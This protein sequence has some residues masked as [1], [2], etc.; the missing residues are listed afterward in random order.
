MLYGLLV[1][2]VHTMSEVKMTGNCL[3]GS[4]PILTFDKNFDSNPQ[5]AL[6]KEIMTQVFC[7]PTHD[8][9]LLHCRCLEVPRLTQ[10]PNLLLIT[11]FHFLLLTIVFGF[12]IIRSNSL[13]RNI[14]RNLFVFHLTLMFNF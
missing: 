10:K 6:I 12:A 13:C 1:F 3:K 8:F 7:S 2:A 14:Y 4:R 9:E 5:Y 11:C